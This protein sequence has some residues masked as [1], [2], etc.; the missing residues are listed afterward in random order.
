MFE[1]AEIHHYNLKHVSCL[2]LAVQGSPCR[3]TQ[4]HSTAGPWPPSS[5]R[6][7]TSALPKAPGLL[8]PI[9]PLVTAVSF[10][11][12]LL[13]N[14]LQS[15]LPAQVPNGIFTA[16]CWAPSSSPSFLQHWGAQCCAQHPRCELSS[17]RCNLGAYPLFF[18]FSFSLSTLFPPKRSLALLTRS[19]LWAQLSPVCFYKQQNP[20]SIPQFL[21]ESHLAKG[22][23]IGALQSAHRNTAAWCVVFSYGRSPFMLDLQKKQEETPTFCWSTGAF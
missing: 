5:V 2:I 1:G 15:S 20:A 10:L 17:M 21:A 23:F 3:Y 11:F 19:R 6:F 8:V 9:L 18:L 7:W 12:P 22:I 14:V 4:H 13:L 16:L